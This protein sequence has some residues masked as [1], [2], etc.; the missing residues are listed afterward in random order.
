M[1]Q[2]MTFESAGAELDA[3]LAELSDEETPLERSLA[4]YAKAAE[5]IAFCDETLKKAQ[6]TVEEIDTRFSGRT[7]AP[8]EKA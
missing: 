5:L 8:E 2:E 7:Q 1:K 6:V 4:L 3:I